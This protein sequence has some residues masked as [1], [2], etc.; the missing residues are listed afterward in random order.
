MWLFNRPKSKTTIPSA[1]VASGIV[2][3]SK[4]NA[5]ALRAKIVQQISHDV[6]CEIRR[7]A[8]IGNRGVRFEKNYDHG[9]D[10]WLVKDAVDIVIDNLLALGYEHI[11]K[12]L[13][14]DFLGSKVV[15]RFIIP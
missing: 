7:S 10:N 5:D 12:R 13:V 6:A 9:W 4:A 15:L 14:Q 11:E 8:S 2:S 1:Y 3:T